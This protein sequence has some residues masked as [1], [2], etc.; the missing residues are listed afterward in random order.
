MF[1]KCQFLI[2]CLDIQ[3]IDRKSPV[4]RYIALKVRQLGRLSS[5][6]PYQA[7]GYSAQNYT[8]KIHTKY[9]A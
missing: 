9:L 6:A 5:L 8:Y 3:P 2:I 4:V 7:H 1:S